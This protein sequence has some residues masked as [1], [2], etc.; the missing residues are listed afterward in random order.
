MEHKE[1]NICC[2]GC[3]RI[4]F[5]EG[6]ETTARQLGEQLIIN[7]KGYDNAEELTKIIKRRLEVEYGVII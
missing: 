7:V 1:G 4:G 6:K 3:Y 2:E 5:K